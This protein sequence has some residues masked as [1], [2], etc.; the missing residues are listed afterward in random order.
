MREF[1]ARWISLPTSRKRLFFQLLVS[2]HLLTRR[3]LI[4]Y[5]SASEY[6]NIV[7]VYML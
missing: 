1:R 7:T 4:V 3:V 5:L 6:F 2:R